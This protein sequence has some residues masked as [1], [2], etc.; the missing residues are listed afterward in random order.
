M[1]IIISPAKKMNVN[2]DDLPVEG[3]PPFLEQTELLLEAVRKMSFTRVRELWKCNE[4]LARLN[5][6]RFARMDLNRTLTPAILAYEG[7]QYQHMAP[8]VFSETALS[9]VREH[10]RILSGF[11]GMLS[12]FDGVVPYRLEMQA[13]LSV[14]GKKDLY[15][16]WGDKI[17]RSLWDGDRT[18]VNLASREYSGV[19][20]KYLQ[21][22]DRFITVVFG[23]LAGG[24]VKQKGTFAKMA[25]GEMVRFMAENN[26][27][28]PEGIKRF[29]GLG[30]R[31]A[32]EY[33]SRDTWVFLMK[34]SISC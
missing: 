13:A 30:Y 8:T 1:R 11:Y 24:C 28:E 9:Y 22:E 27:E 21:P 25:R 2:M 3:L 6:E 18:V 20:E 34:K 4:K 26:I 17:Y 16:F 19:V 33:S 14:D 32:G 12:P 31:Y 15:D 7:L 5:Y 29:E 10:L 23:E